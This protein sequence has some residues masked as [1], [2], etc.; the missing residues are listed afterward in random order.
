MIHIFL[1]YRR[2]DTADA[3]GRLSDRLRMKFGEDL[4]FHDVYDIG[5]G[6][7]WRK[8]ITE[9]LRETDVVL[10]LLGPTWLT[11]TDAKGR[12]RLDNP[13]DTVRNELEQAIGLGIPIIPVLVGS[14]TMPASDDFPDSL[15]RIYELN[16]API[17]DTDFEYD[18]GRL[19]QAIQKYARQ[20]GSDGLKEIEAGKAGRLGEV[21]TGSEIFWEGIFALPPVRWAIG[22]LCAGLIFVL[23]YF[24][25]PRHYFERLFSKPDEARLRLVSDKGH[26][27]SSIPQPLARLRGVQEG[28]ITLDEAQSALNRLGFYKHPP[29]YPVDQ[30]F[31]DAIAAYQKSRNMTP[32]GFLGAQTAQALKAEK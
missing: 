10:A 15:K 23:I 32:D 29:G 4:V 27:D 6:I 18:F 20:D 24:F 2:T 16:A 14:A 7:D 21:A 17:R 8:H 28:V 9:A 26:T 5:A 30:S 13:Q 25:N 12:R 19:F 1:S 3:A 11:A 22:A 31:Y